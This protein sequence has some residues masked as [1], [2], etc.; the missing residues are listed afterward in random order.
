M[1]PLEHCYTLPSDTLLDQP[2]LLEILSR[3]HT[4]I[5][6][7]TPG[8]PQ[9]IVALLFCKASAPTDASRA[10]LITP[11]HHRSPLMASLGAAAVAARAPSGALHG[12][13]VHFQR[14]L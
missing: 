8:A 10:S 14:A 4:R 6:I 2:T 9:R 12:Y 3:G 13:L 5:P 7:H 11:D 1:T